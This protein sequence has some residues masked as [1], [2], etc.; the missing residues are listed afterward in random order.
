MG[1]I[2]SYLSPK[3]VCEILLIRFVRMGG[4]MR[5]IRTMTAGIHRSFGTHMTASNSILIVTAS[6]SIMSGIKYFGW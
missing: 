4:R 2:A 1:C 6:H 5:R 3:P